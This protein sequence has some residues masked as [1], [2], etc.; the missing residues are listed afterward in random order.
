[1]VGDANFNDVSKHSS[2]D[3]ISFTMPFLHVLLFHNIYHLLQLL[4]LL[5]LV[6]E[7]FVDIGRKCLERE[8]VDD[9]GAKSLIEEAD[10]AF[11]A[12]R[13]Q[14]AARV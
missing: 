13:S 11:R 5:S 1:M 7:N 4:F 12:H 6:S 3:V 14:C 2:I 10:L 9:K 8:S